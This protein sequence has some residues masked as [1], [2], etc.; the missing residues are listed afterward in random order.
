[1]GFKISIIYPLDLTGAGLGLL[2]GVE[3]LELLVGAGL[4]ALGE[5]G[6]LQGVS[7]S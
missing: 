2:V 5:L 7:C 4:L 1:M 6:G 3:L